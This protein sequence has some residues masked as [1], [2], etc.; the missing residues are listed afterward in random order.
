MNAIFTYCITSMMG[1]VAQVLRVP[2]TRRPLST[3]ALITATVIWTATWA[4]SHPRRRSIG[5]SLL[6]YNDVWKFWASISRYY[7]NYVPRRAFRFQRSTMLKNG[8]GFSLRFPQDLTS[9]YRILAGLLHLGDVQFCTK[10]VKHM[11]DR[12]AIANHQTLL[13]GYYG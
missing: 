11:A 1:Y 12:S 7:F 4:N 13:T 5:S 10:E 2:Q 6:T 3:C 9:L 8:D